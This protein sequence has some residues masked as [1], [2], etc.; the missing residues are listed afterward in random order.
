MTGK[1]QNRKFQL[2]SQYK[3]L[4]SNKIETEI[5]DIP[6]YVATQL[7][8]DNDVFDEFCSILVFYFTLQS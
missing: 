8:S 1:T 2:K 7:R 6:M 5:K 3:I 4:N